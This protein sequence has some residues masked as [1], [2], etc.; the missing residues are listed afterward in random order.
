MKI[1][2]YTAQ[3]PVFTLSELMLCGTDQ[4]GRSFAP[5]PALNKKSVGMFYF[6]W[7]GSEERMSGKYNITRLLKECPDELWDTNGTPNSPVN[8]FHYWNEPLFGYYRS[9][10]KWVLAKHMEM[11]TL[12]GVD[13]LYLD[14]TNADPYSGS[15][16]NLAAV[17]KSMYKAGW[18]APKVAFYTNSYSILTIERIYKL[19]YKSGRYDEVWYRPDGEHPMIIGNITTASDKAE[20]KRRGDTEYDPQPLSKELTEYFDLRVSQWPDE[21]YMTAGFPWMEWSYPQPIHIQPDGSG[22][23]SVSLARSCR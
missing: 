7:L 5:V 20:A 15:F 12:A 9:D 23:M 3:N 13:F 4:F 22:M 19:L 18:N 1:S 16:K 21:A 17:L 11:L 8:T 14:A 10:D 2:D 6:L